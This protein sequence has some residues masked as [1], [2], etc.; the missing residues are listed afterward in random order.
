MTRHAL[1]KPQLIENFITMKELVP[2]AGVSRMSIFRAL[3]MVPPLPSHTFGR[4]R[5]FRWSEV[6]AWL[7][8]YGWKIGRTG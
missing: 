3:K 2:L 7:V 1:E 8:E 5:R 4:A 6:A